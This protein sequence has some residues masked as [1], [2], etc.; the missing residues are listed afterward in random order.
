[1]TKIQQAKEPFLREL[2]GDLQVAKN[3]EAA[4]KLGRL[5]VECEI[6][7]YMD[8]PDEGST[9]VHNGLDLTLTVTQKI[10]RKVDMYKYGNLDIPEEHDPVKIVET[11]KLDLKAYRLLKVEQ[12]QIYKTLNKCITSTPAKPSFKLKA[13]E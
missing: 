4:A 5:N 2:I 10:N 7:K 3:R 12:L 6:M 1:M 9:S 11:G 8:V 13:K